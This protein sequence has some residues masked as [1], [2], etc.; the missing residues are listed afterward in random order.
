MSPISTVRRVALWTVATAVLTTALILGGLQVV[1]HFVQK[2]RTDRIETAVDE[3]RDNAAAI[4][5]QTDRA[6]EF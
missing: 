4:R 2:P 6:C 1:D 5:V 3:S